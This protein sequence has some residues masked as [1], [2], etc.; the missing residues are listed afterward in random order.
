MSFFD[1]LF[2][3]AT[4]G[5]ERVDGAR[6]RSLVSEGAALVDV[7]SPAEFASGH[8]DGALNVPVDRIATLEG[9]VAKDKPVV[10]YCASGMR[11][12]RAGALLK[13]VGYQT[14]YDLGSVSRW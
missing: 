3:G 8:I 6:A 13:N 4:P 7:R 11:S 12:A 1:R 14:V 5:A 10:L 2:G 9:Q